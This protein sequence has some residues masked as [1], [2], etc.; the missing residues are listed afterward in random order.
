MDKLTNG[1]FY[2]EINDEYFCDKSFHQIQNDVS[3]R[4]D[5]INY[6]ILHMIKNF[7]LLEYDS[8]NVSDI[9][10]EIYE[11]VDIK[12]LYMQIKIQETI[13]NLNTLDLLIEDIGPEKME[14]YDKLR[15]YKLSIDEILNPIKP[16][17]L[18]NEIQKYLDITFNDKI[19]D[20]FIL[21]CIILIDAKLK[22]K[23]LMPKPNIPLNIQKPTRT[24]NKIKIRNHVPDTKKSSPKSINNTLDANMSHV[25][26]NTTAGKIFKEYLDP[27][28]H[29]ISDKILPFVLHIHE[30]SYGTKPKFHEN[31]QILNSARTP[32]GQDISF[33]SFFL[34]N[35]NAKIHR[36]VLSGDNMTVTYPFTS[37]TCDIEDC[38]QFEEEE[39]SW[40]N[41]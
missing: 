20:Q 4:L 41:L 15:L 24:G 11:L 3:S 40:K 18:T 5:D 14:I 21:S 8:K 10:S 9:K 35:E 28:Y 30:Q 33:K 26:P 38:A 37:Y 22:N 39:L 2:D 25:E 12:N 36:I 19:A 34:Y 31:V 17:D 7:H 1:I 16:N 32:D 13:D 23:L 6:Q 29:R 27:V